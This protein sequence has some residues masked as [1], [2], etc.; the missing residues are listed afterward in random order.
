M[1]GSRR[2]A[3]LLVCT[4]LMTPA[5]ALANCPSSDIDIPRNFGRDLSTSSIS[6]VLVGG[7][8]AAGA[9]AVL[10]I[11]S[12]GAVGIFVGIVFLGAVVPSMRRAANDTLNALDNALVM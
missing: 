1:I 3:L 11:G 9:A 6:R 5:Q 7:A 4:A 8:V 10:G 2:L 12:V